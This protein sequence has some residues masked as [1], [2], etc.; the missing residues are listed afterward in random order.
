MSYNRY[1]LNNTDGLTIFNNKNELISCFTKILVVL[2]PC[3]NLGTSCGN[4]E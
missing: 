4:L 1:L 3:H 2:L